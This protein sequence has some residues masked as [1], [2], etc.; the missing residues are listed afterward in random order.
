MHRAQTNKCLPMLQFSRSWNELIEGVTISGEQQRNCPRCSANVMSIVWNRSGIG[1]LKISQNTNI[2]ARMT[3]MA[4]FVSTLG[5]YIAS[6]RTTP[7]PQRR[8]VYKAQ[9][10]FD[11][12]VGASCS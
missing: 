4:M 8:L 5:L 12:R 10:S 9:P 1:T 3:Q 11:T 2:L 7:S 6:S